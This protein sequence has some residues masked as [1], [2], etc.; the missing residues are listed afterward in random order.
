VSVRHVCG[1]GPGMYVQEC[2]LDRISMSQH[3]ET[4]PG[5]CREFLLAVRIRRLAQK[6]WDDSVVNDTLQLL[7]DLANAPRLPRHLSG[8]RTIFFILV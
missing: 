4:I 1:I 2:A 5:D 8:H 3:G 7:D 6:V